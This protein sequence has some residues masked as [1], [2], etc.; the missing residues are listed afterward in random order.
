MSRENVE[1][2]R[3]FYEFWR[4]RDYSRIEPLVHPNAEVDVTRNI[5]NPGIHRGLD[6]YRR[7][8]EQVDEVWEDLEITPE[9]LIDG[10][11]TV[12]VAHRLCGKGRGSGAEVEMRLY[13]V[14]TLR[15]GKVIRFIGG[16][17]DRDE[18]LEAAGLRE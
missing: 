3:Q 5:F 7:L 18:A 8:I 12:F 4:D 13:G 1:I 16:F 9:E 2:V 17:R 14:C 6:G 15:E 10:G 11:D